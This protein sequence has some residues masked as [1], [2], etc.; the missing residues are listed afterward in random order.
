MKTIRV[1]Q[2]GGPEV[3]RIAEVPLPEPSAGQVRIRVA[4]AGINFIDCYRRAGHY[5]VP[6]PFTPGSEVAG[7]V[8]VVG[9]QV[10]EF[11]V[12]DLVATT[13]AAGGYAECVL[14][15][16]DRCVRVPDN[17][18]P[19]DAAA[20]LLQGM[21][22]HYL[23]HGTF[24]LQRGD[25]CLIHAAAGGVGLLV[26]QTSKRIG[27]RTIGTVSTDEK[28]ALARAAGADEIVFYTRENLVERVK[29]LTGGRGVQ[30]VYDSVGRTTFEPGLDCLAPRGTMVLFGQ[31]SGAVAPFDPQILNRKGSLFLT[32]PTLG[33]YIASRYELLQ[34]ADAVLS[35]VA[36]G[37]L[38]VRIDRE[39]SLEQA[40]EAHRLLE[41]R[42][43]S[44]K[45]LLIP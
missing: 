27:A 17:V 11:S 40:P 31:S 6:L 18:S 36:D 1:E 22:A 26:C 10:S 2:T 3:M 29:A 44:G 4:A 43:T 34:R 5:A 45:V 9:A 20:V 33:H 8:E 14:A 38:K 23:L 15:P 12:G 32:R 24:R 19:R 13:D 41:S 39:L 30:V 42:A 25:T 28:A 21:T 7:I 37:T 16:A 35:A